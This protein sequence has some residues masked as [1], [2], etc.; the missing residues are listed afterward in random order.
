MRQFEFFASKQLFFV[1][2]RTESCCTFVANQQK[3]CML[4]FLL[5]TMALFLYSAGYAQWMKLNSGTNQTINDIHF[6]SIDTGYAVGQQATILKTVNAGQ[7]WISLSVPTSADLKSVYFKNNLDGFVVGQNSMLHTQD[8]GI[9]WSTITIS[10]TVVLNDIYFVDAQI[11]FAAAN[12]GI[13]LKT[14]DG[15]FNWQ[16]INT[17]ATDD[18]SSIQFPHPDTG[19]AVQTGYNW[20][21]L[22]TVDAG[23][24]WTLD[25]I[26]PI[27][28]WS[29]I[30]TVY[31]TTAQKGFI[32]GW[33]L[34]AFAGTNN[35]GL[36]WHSLDSSNSINLNSI[37]F[38]NEMQGYAVGYDN[39]IYTSIDGGA[40]WSYDIVNYSYFSVVSG[41]A[42][43]A[44][45][46]AGS[47]GVILK[48]TIA[49]KVSKLAFDIKVKVFPNP[50]CDYVDITIPLPHK[51]LMCTL[52][53]AKGIML[54]QTKV[55]NS[56]LRINL[57]SY[58][59]A[60]YFLQIRTNKKII[61]TYQISKK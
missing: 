10:P 21:F 27:S 1:G 49:T 41:V 35:G 31:F 43:Q 16:L 25:T 3:Q 42:N 33:Y 30:Q 40:T 34:S 47:N 58:T 23:Q 37:Y 19:Y 17:P 28:G 54:Q 7:Q 8:G 44:I 45:Y 55:N 9:N 32:G 48:K 26:Q 53:N 15:G 11:G 57:S 4:K 38:L 50:S 18:I 20:S 46:V 51:N 22:K 24:T 52:F 36:S 61:Y 39:Q 6:S 14:T 56:S 59:A 2:T 13:L 29:N 12:A 60:N 5:I